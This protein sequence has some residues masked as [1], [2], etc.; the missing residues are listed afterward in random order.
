[1]IVHSA[2]YRQYSTALESCRMRKTVLRTVVQGSHRDKSRHGGA[3]VT[4]DRPTTGRAFLH[5]HLYV[6][7]R[8]TGFGADVD[9]PKYFKKHAARS[10]EEK[11]SEICTD[12]RTLYEAFRQD[13]VLPLPEIYDEYRWFALRSPANFV[14]SGCLLC[15]GG[16]SRH[17]RHRLRK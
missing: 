2:Y 5:I 9:F 14:Q 12:S 8:N 16:A 3:R 17:R 10:A 7:T 4:R 13:Y 1:M 11:F 15:G 6:G